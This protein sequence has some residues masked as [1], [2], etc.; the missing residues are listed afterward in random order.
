MKTGTFAIRKEFSSSL[1]DIL[2]VNDMVVD[3]PAHAFLTRRI[4]AIRPYPGP[5]PKSKIRTLF[6]RV[7]SIAVTTGNKAFRCERE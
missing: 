1:T 5:P 2:H 7:S 3:S 6:R 4:S